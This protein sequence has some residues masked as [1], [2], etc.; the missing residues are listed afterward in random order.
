[1]AVKIIIRRKLSTEKGPIV[2]SPRGTQNK[3]H[4]ATGLYLRRDPEERE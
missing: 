1:M 2:A 3:G 4:K